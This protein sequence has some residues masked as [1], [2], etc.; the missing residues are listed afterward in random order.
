MN[1]YLK[2][3]FMMYLS[4]FTFISKGITQENSFEN[5][6]DVVNSCTDYIL[7][8]YPSYSEGLN[9]CRWN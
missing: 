5:I 7:N 1:Y 9:F 2:I 8:V 4:L 6:D 3:F